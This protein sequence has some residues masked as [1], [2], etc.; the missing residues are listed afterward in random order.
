MMRTLNALIVLIEFVAKNKAEV[1]VT[2]PSHPAQHD[3]RKNSITS[4]LVREVNHSTDTAP[5]DASL[6]FVINILKFI[7]FIES[8]SIRIF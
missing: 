8:L 2:R 5:P 1:K 7:C 6:R 3:V 4:L